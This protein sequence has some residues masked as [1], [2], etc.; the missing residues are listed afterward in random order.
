MEKDKAYMFGYK[1]GKALFFITACCLAAIGV[2][3]TIKIVS[4]LIF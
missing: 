3:L 2:A 4:L 1:I